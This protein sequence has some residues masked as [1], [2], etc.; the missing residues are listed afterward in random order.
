[1]LLR[2]IPFLFDDMGLENI[3]HDLCTLHLSTKSYNQV[4][5]NHT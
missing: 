4:T 5:K 3:F 2:V 1:M